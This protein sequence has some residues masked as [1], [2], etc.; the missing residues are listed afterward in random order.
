MHNTYILFD[1]DGTLTD[2]M[3]GITNAVIYALEQFDI[4]GFK[5]TD[6]LHFI[7]PP[8]KDSFMQY[9][10]FDEARA[11]EAIGYFRV[12]FK[13]KGI[14]ENIPYDGIKEMLNDLKNKGCILAVAT[15]KPEPF[16]LDILKHF[17]MSD[18]FDFVGGSKL[19]NTRTAKADVIAHVL[20]HLPVTATSKLFMVGD[21]KHDIIGAQAHD[22]SS[23]GVLYGYGS[24]EELVAAQANHIVKNV[25]ELKRLLMVL[26][27]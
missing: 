12:Y 3:E 20:E 17:G 19:D 21:R 22:I 8:L 4:S 27:E 23:I 13:E 26:A 14:F 18:Y 16:A 10:G 5:N 25:D 6:L 24:E 9:F 15:S 11:L 7:G 1:L 2:P